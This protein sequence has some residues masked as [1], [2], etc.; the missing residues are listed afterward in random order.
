MGHAVSGADVFEGLEMPCQR[1]LKPAA[2]RGG[3]IIN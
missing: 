3:R 2:I 1:Q